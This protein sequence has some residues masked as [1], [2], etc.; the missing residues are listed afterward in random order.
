MRPSGSSVSAGAGAAASAL[1]RLPWAPLLTPEDVARAQGYY[2]SGRAMR[3]VAAKLLSG[4]P[5]AVVTLGGSITRG[6]GASKPAHAYASRFFAA[7]NASF[8]HPQHTF[9]NHGIG[10]TTS[11]I[12]AACTEQLVPEGADLVVSGS[13]RVAAS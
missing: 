2:G 7:L 1:E 10:G 12:F 11:T 6:T 8:P 3:R 13:P 5:V 4:Q 9:I